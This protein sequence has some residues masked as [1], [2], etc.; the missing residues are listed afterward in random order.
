MDSDTAA[1][2][3]TSQAAIEASQKVQQQ[4]A[5]NTLKTTEQIDQMLGLQSEANGLLVAI[6]D[7]PSG[8]SLHDLNGALASHASVSSRSNL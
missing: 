4:I 8:I 6:K 5:D 3:A 7:K 1:T 2:T